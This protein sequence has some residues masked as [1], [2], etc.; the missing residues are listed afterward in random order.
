[1]NN[2]YKL[3]FAWH[4]RGGTM[5]NVVGEN[6]YNMK[7]L[8][9]GTAIFVAPNRMNGT[10]GWTNTNGQDMNFLRSM[11]TLF[12]GSLC[13]DQNRIFS[14]GW[15]YGGMMSFAVGRELAGTIRAIA[16]ASGALYT[17]FTDSGQPTAAWISHGTNDD[18]V[19][20][21]N[22]I[23]AR[24]LYISTNRCSNTTVPVSPSGCVEYQNC[25]AGHPVVW[26]S[27]SG[28]H[29]TPSYY[30]SAVWSF[31]SRF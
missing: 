20:Q 12:K 13:I 4:W 25:A 26:C 28:G 30:S 18:V 23:A 8:S 14:A 10:D 31:F 11:L 16:P 27:F 1:M 7:G 15:S 22:G 6:Y 29:Q 2:P 19:P 24:D 9:N 5:D 17:P 3:V 21:S